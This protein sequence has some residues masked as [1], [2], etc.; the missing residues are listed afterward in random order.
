MSVPRS[1]ARH[2][3]EPPNPTGGTG[4]TTTPGVRI[5]DRYASTSLPGAATISGGTASHPLAFRPV[6]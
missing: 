6:P 4:S 3:T 2:N 5:A 1:G